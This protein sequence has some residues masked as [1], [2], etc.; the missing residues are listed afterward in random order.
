M[1]RIKEAIAVAGVA[2]AAAAELTACG[3]Q[4][5]VQEDCIQEAHA[6]P[7]TLPN[8]VHAV[9]A[10]AR[11]V[12]E[13]A[14]HFDPAERHTVAGSDYTTTVVLALHN[15]AK[16]ELSEHSPE[17]IQK[18]HVADPDKA[19]ALRFQF[20]GDP[21]MQTDLSAIE[22]DVEPSSSDETPL[23]TFWV[24][25]AYHQ[26]NTAPDGGIV[27]MEPGQPTQTFKDP[28]QANALAEQTVQQA[29]EL[30]HTQHSTV[31]PSFS[32]QPTT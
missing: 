26:V 23:R 27:I 14:Q 28:T 2:A 11:A 20:F 7:K 17:M 6:L 31:V 5:P 4:P 3:S 29:A 30:L 15:G 21:D 32:A 10:L 22:L 16:L 24:E 12:V 8:N 1:G 13:C 25:N 19:T 9:R 18:S